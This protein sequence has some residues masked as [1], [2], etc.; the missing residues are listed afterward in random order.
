MTQDNIFD[1]YGQYYDLLY[2]DKDY[3]GEVDYIN[4]LLIQ[5]GI[6][7]SELLEFG[8]GTGIHG[9]LLAKKGYRVHGIELS[10]RMVD[11][12]QFE[13]GFTC[14]QGDIRTISLDKKYSVVLSLFHVVSYLTD[15]S[16]VL[17]V[18]TRANEHLIDGGL[19]VFDFWYSPAVFT[20]YPEVR[21]KRIEDDL[22]EITRLAE[23]VTYPNESRVDVGYT[24]F[25][26]NKT[27]G[28]SDK[29]SENHPMRHFSLLEIDLFAK[30]SGFERVVTEEFLTGKAPSI[31]TWGVCVTLRKIV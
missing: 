2:R 21:I 23:P 25:V 26:R 31:D 18:F 20:Q 1:A 22:V 28:R 9:S 13:H 29:I 12:V 6:V 24:I 14:Q 10:Q 8:S 16:D 27:S 30:I 4:R 7:N 15:N 11:Q 17:K 3:S 19:F 5:N